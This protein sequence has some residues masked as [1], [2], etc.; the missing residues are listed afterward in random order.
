MLTEKEF[1]AYKAQG[2]NLIPI[3]KKINLK[4]LPTSIDLYKVFSG[5]AQDFIF[6]YVQKGN[7]TQKYSIIGLKSDQ[8]FVIKNEKVEE[9]AQNKLINT[10]FTQDP[11]SEFLQ[12]I[13]RW[14][15]PKI[16]ALPT[17]I[18]GFFG[19]FNTECA[20]LYT[21]IT[22]QHDVLYC[23]IQWLTKSLIVLD[24]TEQ[25]IYCITHLKT[26]T[27]EDYIEGYQNLAY[28]TKKT[29][30]FLSISD[31]HPSNPNVVE[32]IGVTEKVNLNKILVTPVY[33]N[34][35]SLFF[36]TDY[37]HITVKKNAIDLYGYITKKVKK[38][39]HYFIN[40]NKAQ[41]LGIATHS[42]LYEQNI[43]SELREFFKDRTSLT[44]S[45]EG[46][47][48][49][50]PVSITSSLELCGGLVGYIDFHQ[51]SHYIPILHTSLCKHQ[52]FSFK[53]AIAVDDQTDLNLAWKKLD[54]RKKKVQALL[55]EAENIKES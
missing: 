18:G 3:W 45:Q 55:E 19:F 53:S 25:S 35:K 22:K 40:F 29:E 15:V 11:I 24:H 32:K 48:D 28:L 13:K 50:T 44:C 54:F 2:F 27:I 36:L 14:R 23:A 16:C 47:L 5:A 31:K 42:V 39:Y 7:S 8:W 38:T 21:P 46:I 9:Y 20:K 52:I 41:M 43:T 51:A 30:L 12:Q 6:E 10:I 33:L 4:T 26:N 37:V 34:R 49:T 1:W 17:F